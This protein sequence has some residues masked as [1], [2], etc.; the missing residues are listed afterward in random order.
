MD[1]H[2]DW[3]DSRPVG[4]VS[5]DMKLG[6]PHHHH[7]CDF[8]SLMSKSQLRCPDDVQLDMKVGFSECDELSLAGARILRFQDAAAGAAGAPQSL[9]AGSLVR[10][11][12]DRR[13]RMSRTRRPRPLVKPL[14][15]NY[16]VS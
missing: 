13:S 3:C 1:I 6:K 8:P 5:V 2:W 12:R 9:L 16:Y 4:G 15:G 14:P 10:G 7:H 11:E